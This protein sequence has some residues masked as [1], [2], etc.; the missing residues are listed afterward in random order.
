[1]LPEAVE[2]DFD[3]SELLN[4]A[5]KQEQR[6]KKLA[7]AHLGKK[8]YKVQDPEMQGFYSRTRVVRMVGGEKIVIQ[9]R[10][11]PLDTAC[12]KK[13]RRVLGNVVPDITQLHDEELESLG[14]SIYAMTFMPGGCLMREPDSDIEKRTKIAHSLGA[15]LG[16][17]LVAEQSADAVENY[18]LPSLEDCRD[19]LEQS[20]E[21]LRPHVERLIAAGPGVSKFPL[22]ISHFDLNEMNILIG[23]DSTVSAIVD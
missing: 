9:F 15:I 7:A 1:M 19:K 12:F 14:V 8:A 3:L 13:A 23:E 16:G 5:A 18:I 20:T 17:G 10:I 6:A 11:Q 21:V 2:D 22:H 4:T